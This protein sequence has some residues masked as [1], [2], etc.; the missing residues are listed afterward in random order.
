MRI[1]EF[2][3]YYYELK[4]L[5][6]SSPCLSCQKPSSVLVVCI[7]SNHLASIS[8]FTSQESSFRT[9]SS[10]LEPQKLKA[11]FWL[12][13]W[14]LTQRELT[15]WLKKPHEVASHN[16]CHTQIQNPESSID[17]HPQVL[18]GFRPEF[19]CPIGY[20]TLQVRPFS[21]TTGPQHS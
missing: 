5:H 4:Q 12:G 14:Y 1:H 18:Y 21:N 15:H 13:Q 17:L 16:I 20:I 2:H 11:Q 9:M 7:L 3:K 6:M 10:W 8:I 19:K